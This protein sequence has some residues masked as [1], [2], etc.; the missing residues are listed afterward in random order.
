M[1]MQYHQPT[2]QIKISL[3]LEFLESSLKL[4]VC[5]YDVEIQNTFYSS[6]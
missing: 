3:K 1:A 6:Y 5:Y 2:R 4:N